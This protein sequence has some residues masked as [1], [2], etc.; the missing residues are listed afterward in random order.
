MARLTS[1][2]AA[3]VGEFV[4]RQ[5]ACHVVSLVLVQDGGEVAQDG[6]CDEISGDEEGDEGLKDVAMSRQCLVFAVDG[7]GVDEERAPRTRVAGAGVGC[8]GC[9][10]DRAAK[11]GG[12]S[13][14]AVRA[15]SG[16]VDEGETPAVCLLEVGS[17]SGGGCEKA[18]LGRSE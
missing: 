15:G 9:G 12:Q 13:C 6:V 16:W 17:G 8:A 2:G 14:S 10:E 3:E 7:E 5:R 18:R 1:D 11:G 4:C